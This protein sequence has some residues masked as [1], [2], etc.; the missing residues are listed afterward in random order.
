MTKWK[1][2]GVVDGQVCGKKSPEAQGE[3]WR[4][5]KSGVQERAPKAQGEHRSPRRSVGRSGRSPKRERRRPKESATELERAREAQGECQRF[6]KN[7]GPE[8]AEPQ[9]ER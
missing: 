3:R 8:R 1:E 6:R 4:A 9:G 2:W 7:G 5:C